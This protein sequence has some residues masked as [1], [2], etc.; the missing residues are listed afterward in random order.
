VGRWCRDYRPCPI[1]G[2][3][4]SAS[5]ALEAGALIETG[6]GSRIQRLIGC[7]PVLDL[8]DMVVG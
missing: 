2:G 4:R 3:L 8:P 6:R 1:C 7:R 5:W